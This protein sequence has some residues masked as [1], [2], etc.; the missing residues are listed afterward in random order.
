MG[1]H[2]HADKVTLDKAE[3][4]A[5][6]FFLQNGQ[7]LS[8]RSDQLE[9]AWQGTGSATRVGGGASP[10][11]YVFNRGNHNGFVIISGYSLIIY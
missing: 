1:L 5:H 2:A 10:A 8:S 7:Q 4:Y 11:F 9:L 3:A 6:R